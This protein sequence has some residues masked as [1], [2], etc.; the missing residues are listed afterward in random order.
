MEGGMREDGVTT[1]NGS[2]GET[3]RNVMVGGAAL[4]GALGVSAALR[5][6]VAEASAP[7]DW[8]NVKVDY[9][10]KGDG[11]TDDTTA[12]SNAI[13]AANT[14]GGGI[15]Y[16]PPG[17]YITGQQT[18]YSNVYLVGAGVGASILKLKNSGNADLLKTYQFDSLTGTNSESGPTHFGIFN[19]TL[20]GNKANNTSGDALKIYGKSYRINQVDI[21]NWAGRGL[22]SEWAS[23][24]DDME[25]HLRSFKIHDCGGDGINW[26]GPHDS[27]IEQFQVFRNGTNGI[28]QNN[29]N[30]AGTVWIA[31][32][33]WGAGHTYAWRLEWGN[34]LIACEGEGASD[35]QLYIRGPDGIV[36]GGHFFC[37]SGGG[38]NYGIKLG[39][40][41]NNALRWLIGTKIS[42]CPTA[43]IV[44]AAGYEQFNII[45]S[46]ILLPT[47]GSPVAYSGTPHTTD[48]LELVVDN[49]QSNNAN[50]Y[51]QMKGP[52]VLGSAT[53]SMGF[54]GGSGAT[55][56]TVT[57]S[58]GGN[59][60]LASLMSALSNLGLVVDSTT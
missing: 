29:A 56:P 33:V 59:A 20:D 36:A 43:G 14:A 10:A 11:S 40:T 26:N 37:T 41:S 47:G 17:T 52:S 50:C 16:F 27:V 34:Y 38:G 6:D 4:L 12:I 30:G 8:Y 24:G 35:T 5:P 46:Q 58:K 55:Q 31:G 15:V 54:F 2:R 18:L 1:D 7:S 53:A 48:R 28:W 13:S 49:G 45:H 9:N 23:S 25:A 32:H 39:A 42:N 44:F 21:Y 51:H 22:Y 19:L 3:R 60:A 57:G